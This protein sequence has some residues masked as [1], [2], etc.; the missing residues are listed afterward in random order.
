[1]DYQLFGFWIQIATALL[2]LFTFWVYFFQLRTMK[3]ST[4]GQNSISI[5]NY[6]QDESVRKAREIVLETLR[7]KPISDWTIEEKKAASKVCNTYDLVSIL[8]FQQKLV[9][10]RI[11]IDNWGP[12]IVRCFETLK[13]H[14]IEMQTNDRM[15]PQYWNDFE[16][17]Y[18]AAKKT[19][20]F[21]D[22]S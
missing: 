13:E 4:R 8:I 6:L 1:M 10:P 17:L 7:K 14:I 19:G 2:I 12:S 9:P 15:G 3:K 20:K 18:N 16:K 11:I 21:N 22:L 5:I